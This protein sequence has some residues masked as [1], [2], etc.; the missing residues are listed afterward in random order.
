M[1]AGSCVSKV[2]CCWIQLVGNCGLLVVCRFSWWRRWWRWFGEWEIELDV[3][4][5]AAE[6]SAA[7]ATSSSDETSKHGSMSC[8][9]MQCGSEED[10]YHFFAVD[11]CFQKRVAR[12]ITQQRDNGNKKQHWQQQNQADKPKRHKDQS[13]LGPSSESSSGDDCS[14]GLASTSW[15]AYDDFAK[16]YPHVV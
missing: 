14:K 7:S 5:P 4:R 6:A 9:T 1:S 3:K 2:L 10:R 12:Q 13:S 11:C 16:L 8:K 15:L